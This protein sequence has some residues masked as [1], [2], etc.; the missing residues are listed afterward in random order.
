[1]TTIRDA[2]KTV[3]ADKKVTA[4][5]WKNV[6]KPAADK[7]PKEASADARE[8][9]KLWASDAFEV[10]STARRG[11]RDFLSSRGYEVPA[12]KPAGAKPAELEQ[13][14]IS[15]NV[16][17]ADA[18][19]QSL[20]AAAGRDK[21]EQTIAV[22]DSGFDINHEGLDTKL[23]T[24]PGEIAGDDKDNDGNGKV[25]DIHGWDFSTNDADV[26]SSESQGHATHVTGIATGG[27]DNV[28]SISLRVFSP[29]DS[30]KV[31]EAIDYAAANGA[32]VMNMSFRVGTEAD[33]KAITDAMKRH[34]EVLFVKSA[35]NDGRDID[36]YDADAYLPFR[37]LPNMAVVS[38]ADPNGQKADYSNYGAPYATH[39]TRGTD[40]VSSVPGGGYQPMSGTSMAA[41]GMTNV[42]AKM[43]ILDPGLKP[44]D[45]KQM[46]A[47]TTDRSDAWKDATASGGLIN[48][49]RAYELAALTG[50]MRNGVPADAAAAQ[51]KLSTASKDALLPLAQ[52][53]VK[54]AVAGR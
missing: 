30:K 54:P 4:D 44:T 27:T 33:V 24:N 37:E 31:A 23:W 20:A 12:A 52:E 2:I 53:Y 39:A 40:V 9:A 45:L 13:A 28:N 5:E 47:Q 14:I 22:L 50:L 6:L 51:L 42:A 25:D 8:I 11:M 26:N 48:A 17:E 19:F 21:A 15:S 3:T 36:T 29:F 32:R 10:D 16:T 46:L 35:G 49:Q 38:A 41:P 1:M 34:P 7:A 43:L 18:A